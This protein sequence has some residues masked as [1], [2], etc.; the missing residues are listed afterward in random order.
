MPLLLGLQNPK[1]RQNQP[2]N[3]IEMDVL[4]LEPV[5]RRVYCV[6]DEKLLFFEIDREQT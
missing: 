1:T 6:S 5:E 3:K 4:A 2:E